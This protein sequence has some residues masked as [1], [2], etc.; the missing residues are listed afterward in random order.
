MLCH[1]FRKKGR[2]SSVPTVVLGAALL[3][4]PCA[5]LAQ[6]GGGGGGH[7]G[8]GTAGAGAMGSG[9]KATGV[10]DKDDLKDFHAV[11]AVQATSQQIV[12]YA[13]MLKSTE[14]ASA[15]LKTLLGQLGKE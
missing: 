4:Y 9:G 10:P 1:M 12:E 11:L 15:E 3:A 2:I 13:A 8:G 7:V 5:I 6:H 14:A